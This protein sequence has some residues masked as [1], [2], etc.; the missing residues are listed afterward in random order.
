MAACRSKNSGEGDEK[1]GLP[2]E[3]IAEGDKAIAAGSA[4]DG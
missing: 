2:P 1:G 4:V 3:K